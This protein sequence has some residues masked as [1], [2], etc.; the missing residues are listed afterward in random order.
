[1]SLYITVTG[2]QTFK[3]Q[4]PLETE[5]F[6]DTEGT[7]KRAS[8]FPWSSV[9]V[10]TRSASE[11]RPPLATRQDLPCRPLMILID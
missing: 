3:L 6:N 9:L 2:E 5:V 11:R 1:V 8:Q 10:S 7:K 4:I